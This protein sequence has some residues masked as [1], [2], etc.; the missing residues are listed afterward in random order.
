LTVPRVGDGS[1]GGSYPES[2]NASA[3]YTSSTAKIAKGANRLASKTLSVNY[4]PRNPITT[5]QAPSAD[6][7]H[8]H[9]GLLFGEYDSQIAITLGTGLGTLPLFAKV[10]WKMVPMNVC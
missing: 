5:F 6:R 2:I 8:G 7:L 3:S 10:S 9:L 4:N 1:C